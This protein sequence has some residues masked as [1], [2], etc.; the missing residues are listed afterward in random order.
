MELPKPSHFPLLLT[1]LARAPTDLTSL[2]SYT[3][4]LARVSPVSIQFFR[5]FLPVLPPAVRVLVL[6]RREILHSH[7]LGELA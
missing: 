7:R 6:V 4:P 5:V 1:D 2:F 3:F